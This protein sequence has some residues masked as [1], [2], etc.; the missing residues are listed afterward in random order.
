MPR[1]LPPPVVRRPIP[2]PPGAVGRAARPGSAGALVLTLLVALSAGPAAAQHE[3][4]GPFLD[5]LMVEHGVPGLAFA[6]FDDGGVRS[7]HRAGVKDRVAGGAV[8]PETVFEAA[9]ITKPVFAWT[10]LSLARDGILD[11]DAPLDELVDELPELGYDPRARLL[12]PRLLLSHQGGLPNWRA[13]LSFTAT[14]YDDLFPGGDTLR[15]AADPGM[16]YRYSGEGYVLL[17]RV[18]EARTG[19]SVVDLVWE[20]VFE[21][22]AMQRSSMLFDDRMRADFARGHDREGN[23]DKWELA[24]PLASSTMHTTATDLAAFGAGLA[25]QIRTGGPYAMMAEP[26]VTFGSDGAWEGR[27]GAGLGIVTDG[28]R[29][30][31]YHG[32]NNVIFIADLVYGVEEN[33]GYVLLTNSANGA[34]IVRA[35]QQ[36]VFGLEVRR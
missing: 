30:Y 25:R 10:V 2:R 24:V 16:G 11:L 34:A 3:A 4:L 5:S 31:V 26:L 9:S 18:V 19:R 15:F 33:V 22:L 27:W 8:G 32:G 12:T 14:G 29:R 7:V 20:R 1:T 35:L 21:P 13:R 28:E 6:L 36:R 17:Q 23:P